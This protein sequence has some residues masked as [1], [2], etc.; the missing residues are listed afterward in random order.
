MRSPPTSTSR[1]L[2]VA[3]FQVSISGR[4][5]V[6]TEVI[7]AQER[8]Q[9]RERMHL[10]TQRVPSWAVAHK[11]KSSTLWATE[12]VIAERPRPCRE[13]IVIFREGGITGEVAA[14]F[15]QMCSLTVRGASF[16]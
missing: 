10:G 6:S 4:F 15:A 9:E 8:P 2:R 3:G 13:R 11:Q 16:R 5:W 1:L 7:G 14:R 12:G